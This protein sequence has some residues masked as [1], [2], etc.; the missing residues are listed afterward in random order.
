MGGWRYIGATLA[1]TVLADEEVTRKIE[2]GTGTPQGR[3][4]AGPLDR[5]RGFAAVRGACVL[6]QT[7]PVAARG[8]LRPVRRNTLRTALSRHPRPA[9]HSAGRLLPHVAGRIL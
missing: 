6:P 1:E 3:T 2:N 5:N 9:G 7:Q 4:T 8:R